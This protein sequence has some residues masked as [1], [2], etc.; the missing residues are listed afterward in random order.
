MKNQD[1]GKTLW[2]WRDT[3]LSNNYIDARTLHI[4][5]DILVLKDV[6]K[7]Y[8][9]NLKSGKEIRSVK[10][11]YQA[12]SWGVTGTREKYYY[13]DFISHIII[14]NIKSGDEDTLLTIKPLK[15]ESVFPCVIK[16]F[17]NKKNLQL[18][19]PFLRYDSDKH[20]GQTFLMLYDLTKRKEIYTVPI[21]E[22]NN[23]AGGSHEPIIIKNKVILASGF[24]VV[25]HDIKSGKQLWKTELP[26]DF[27]SSGIIYADGKIIGNCEDTNMYALDPETG[28]I[29]WREKT[30]GTSCTPFYMN[31]V[32]YLAGNGDGLL[33]AVDTK[34]GEHLWRVICPEKGDDSSFVGY[35]T[36]ANGKIFVCSFTTLYC[37]K[38]A[39]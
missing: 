29:L 37:F 2:Q 1:N 18:I 24:L 22:R 19:I 8:L 15:K 16:G 28:K 32:A 31:G 20:E 13:S 12:S 9:I 38:A 5:N 34:I 7:T 10:A 36:G 23:K 39:R 4:Y 17:E 11:A 25:C 6:R 30:T 3:T 26:G 21:N 14:G 33:H 27:M 35:V